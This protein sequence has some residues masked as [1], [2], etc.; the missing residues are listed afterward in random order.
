MVEELAARLASARVL[1]EMP[2][3]RERGALFRALLRAG[4]APMLVGE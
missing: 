4:A 1:V 3:G 2:R